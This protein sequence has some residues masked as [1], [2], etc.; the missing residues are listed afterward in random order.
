MNKNAFTLI[1]LLVVIAI[2]AVLMGILMPSLRLARDQARRVHCVSNAKTLAL[3][4]FMYKDD[5]NEKLVGPKTDGDTSWVDVPDDPQN[6]TLEEKKAA[7][8]QGLLFRYV[9]KEVGVYHCPADSRKQTGSTA[10]RTFSIVGGAGRSG[11]RGDSE[12][13]AA[14]RYSD[15]KR[16]ALQY[17][18]CEEADTRGT[19]EGAWELDVKSRAWVDPMAMWHNKKTTLGF[20][21]GHAEMHP[22]QDDHWIKWCQGAM[23]SP[24]SFSFYLTPPSDQVTDI[25]YAAERFMCKSVPVSR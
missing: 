13:V 25:S 6:A 20:A 12:Y 1:E 24:Q 19:N 10:Y 18:L 9:G 7:I 2:I 23:F 3:A 11:W 8:R 14:R 5:N 22:W 21:D 16:P 4:W 15:I 17:F